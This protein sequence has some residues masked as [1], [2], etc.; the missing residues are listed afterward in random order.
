[1]ARSETGTV[2]LLVD[3]N[4]SGNINKLEVLKS[5]GI[6]KMDRVAMLTIKNDWSFKAYQKGYTIQVRVNFEMD[7]EGN[8]EVQVKL[9]NL[10]F[11]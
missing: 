2:T 10:K 6:D 4:T 11:K 8:S 5:S 9:G 1:M 7:Q 3:I